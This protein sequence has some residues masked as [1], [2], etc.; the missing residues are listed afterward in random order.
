MKFL[1]ADERKDD[2]EPGVDDGVPAPVQGGVAPAPLQ[3]WT[4]YDPAE[5]ATPLHKLRKQSPYGK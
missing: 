3:R 1:Q 2:P 4:Q 5:P